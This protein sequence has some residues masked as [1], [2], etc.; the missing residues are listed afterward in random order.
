MCILIV[1]KKNN[2]WK[3][4]GSALLQLQIKKDVLV[5]NLQYFNMHNIFYARDFSLINLLQD[6]NVLYKNN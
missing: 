1:N 6:K 3:N 4:V 2:K 5:L